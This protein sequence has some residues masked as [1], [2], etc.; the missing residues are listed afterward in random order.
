[1][2]EWVTI[3]SGDL[4]AR[5]DPLGAEPS[6]LT[7][8]AGRELMT[9]ADP[10]FW[11]GRAPLLFPIVGRLNGDVLRVDGR[12]YPMKQH[13]FARRMMFDVAEAGDG[14]AVFALTDSEAT[15]AQYPF[16][17]RLEVAFT[18][19]NATL[20][21]DV[22][23]ANP[24]DTPLPASFG[25]HPAFAWPLPYGHARDEHR[26]IFAA[27]EP[28]PIKR[29]AISLIAADRASPIK[30][31]MLSL[32]DALFTDDALI[33][34]PV[35][36]QS[37][38]YGADTGPQLHIA[39]PDTPQLGIWTKPGARFVCIEPWHGHADP[40]GYTGELRDKPGVFTVAPGGMKRLGMSVSV[41]NAAP[42]R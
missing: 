23:I 13:G 1:M 3:T 14:R 27:D 36:S 15:R 21:I 41:E 35:R 17:F 40:V 30:G 18:L 9:D 31:R 7:D 26:I 22:T 24:A 20:A 34:N 32:S 19:T 33:W 2:A 11:T 38:T 5:I 39:F 29:L 28:G 10:A 16:A 12:E 8:A 42:R 25:F 6:S 4:T 37:L